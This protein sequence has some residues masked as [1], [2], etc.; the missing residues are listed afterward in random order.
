MNG[1]WSCHEWCIEGAS[2]AQN[3]F[4]LKWFFAQK[5]R[6]ILKNWEKGGDGVEWI[7]GWRKGKSKMGGQ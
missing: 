2:I 6:E 1:K 4:F 3:S 7:G 5:Y